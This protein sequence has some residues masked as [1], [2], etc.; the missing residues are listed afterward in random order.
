MSKLGITQ[1]CLEELGHVGSVN[2]HNSSPDHSLME[3]L[4]R[5]LLAEEMQAVR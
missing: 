2:V 1:I 5:E 3:V 4:L